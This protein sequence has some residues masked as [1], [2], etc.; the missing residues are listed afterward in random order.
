MPIIFD[1]EQIIFWFRKMNLF[2][3]D[4]HISKVLNLLS[5][6]EDSINIYNCE[7]MC[8]FLGHILTNIWTDLILH[9]ENNHTDILQK[10]QDTNLL[11]DSNTHLAT[12]KYCKKGDPWLLH[13]T[14]KH[15]TLSN[16]LKNVKLWDWPT[17]FF[18]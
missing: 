18:F 6:T 5:F 7:G 3:K 16:C 8:D 11:E 12:L 14:T 1:D 10:I 15:F 4:D 13:F 2:E 9:L 17:N